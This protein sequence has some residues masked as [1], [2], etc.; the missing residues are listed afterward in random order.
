MSDQ[1]TP[2]IYG[3]LVLIAQKFVGILEIYGGDSLNHR[4]SS[5][6]L[7]SIH[8]WA[9]LASYL[10]ILLIFLGGFVTASGSGLGC[11]PEWPRC[12]HAWVPPLNF[13]AW[14]EWMH[15][16][17]A[18]AVGI[19]ILVLAGKIILLSGNRSGYTWLK[20]LAFLSLFLLLGQVLL[21]ALIVTQDLRAWIIA[22]HMGTAL[23]LAN[24][25]MAI[26]VLSRFTVNQVRSQSSLSLWLAP[27]MSLVTAMLGSYVAHSPAGSSCLRW[28]ECL[29]GS[30]WHHGL[31]WLLAHLSAALTLGIIIAVLL[32]TYLHPQRHFP[33][34]YFLLGATLYGLQ[35]GLGLLL[36][37]SHMD[38]A[39]LS[40][41]EGV[42][43]LVQVSFF[44]SALTP[45]PLAKPFPKKHA[46]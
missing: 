35:I 18:M 36:L 26:V 15:R 34:R 25:L 20:R 39:V 17:I 33:G 12:Q 30:G 29:S 31:I 44:L 38:P 46:F 42:G 37:A 8:K 7:Q 2:K 3:L 14:V 45:L 13:H 1:K 19:I 9:S 22:I 11:G 16:M 28:S 43:S 10:L 27:I 6:N 5:V 21:G 23:L 24:T 32:R 41:H 40:L 4:D